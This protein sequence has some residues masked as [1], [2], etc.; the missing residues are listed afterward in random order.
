MLRFMRISL[1]NQFSPEV[2]ASKLY[3]HGP[4]LKV[5]FAAGLTGALMA[6]SAMAEQA[7]G[8]IANLRDINPYVETS[9]ADIA[10]K[11]LQCWS[12]RQHAG[13]PHSKGLPGC[14]GRSMPSMLGS[15]SVASFDC[16][17]L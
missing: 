14:A 2:F 5:N 3:L 17:C 8:S 13:H 9:L 1:D 15:Q 4:R 6:M 10:A 16:H 12:P 11:G 7:V